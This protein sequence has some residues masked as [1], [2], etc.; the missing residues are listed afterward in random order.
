MLFGVMSS[1][2]VEPR[3]VLEQYFYDFDEKEQDSRITTLVNNSLTGSKVYKVNT[4]SAMNN[5]YVGETGN[6]NAKNLEDL[7]VVTPTL[8]KIANGTI[9]EYYEKEEIT[10]KLS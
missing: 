7:K 2:C 1:P 3:S 9:T 4:K 8:I 6:K 10:N 5:K